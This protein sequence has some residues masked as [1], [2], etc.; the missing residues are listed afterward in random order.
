MIFLYFLIMAVEDCLGVWGMATLNMY[1]NFRD[2]PSWEAR[3][4]FSVRRVTASQG[5]NIS[6]FSNHAC[7]SHEK[8]SCST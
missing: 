7:I 4:Q 8:I 1:R 2:R 5:A 6:G 3:Q